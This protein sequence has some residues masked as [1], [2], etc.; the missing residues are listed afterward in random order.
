MREIRLSILNRFLSSIFVW[1]YSFEGSNFEHI[2]WN[3]FI[4][5]ILERELTKQTM[6]WRGSLMNKMFGARTLGRKRARLCSGKIYG[7][8]QDAEPFSAG[9]TPW[10]L[11]TDAVNCARAVGHFARTGR[12]ISHSTEAAAI[13]WLPLGGRREDVWKF[14]GRKTSKKLREKPRRERER[15]TEWETERE[16]WVRNWL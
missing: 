13:V 4:L 11:Q 1:T 16:N 3:I 6:W 5:S 9:G 12:I 2:R 8:P 10:R 14:K 15:E 7:L